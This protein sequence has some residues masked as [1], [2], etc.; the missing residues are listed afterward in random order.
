MGGVV[1]AVESAYM[2]QRLVESHTA[3]TQA[4]ESGEQIVVG[5]NRF[6][7]AE[8]S[9][10]LAGGQSILEVDASAER[11]QIERLRAFRARRSQAE[12]TAALQNLKDVL[13]SGGNVM[14]PCDPRG[15]RGRHHRRVGRR[16]ARALRRVPRADRR[17]RRA[18]S[19]PPAPRT[20]RGAGA[21]RRRSRPASAAR[22]RS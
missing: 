4:I 6:T 7:E 2:K 15:A 22:S 5:V 3:R 8:P 16:A 21:R 20:P 13:A 12:V 18:A 10:L 14:P 19:P 17:G 1:A 11:E 9:P